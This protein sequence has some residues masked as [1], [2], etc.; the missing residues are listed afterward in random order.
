MINICTI[1]LFIY[2]I[3]MIIQ[4]LLVGVLMIAFTTAFF[5]RAKQKTKSKTI[6]FP[7]D[8]RD[9]SQARYAINENGFL[10]RIEQ[11]KKQSSHA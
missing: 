1:I 9:T 3:V 11:D 10:E 8:Y 5:L 6:R 4:L 2:Y 7:K